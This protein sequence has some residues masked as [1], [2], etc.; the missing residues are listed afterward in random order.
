MMDPISLF[1]KTDED[2]MY[3]HQAMKQTDAIKF[4]K[5]IVKEISDLCNRKHT[6]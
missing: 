5:A 4:K 3:F 2:T 1:A 6:E